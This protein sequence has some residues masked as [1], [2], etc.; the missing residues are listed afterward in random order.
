MV[1]TEISRDI[2]AAHVVNR[3]SHRQHSVEESVNTALTGRSIDD[4][5][6]SKSSND[7]TYE[8][9]CEVVCTG[10]HG[11]APQRNEGAE[12]GC[13]S[14]PRILAGSLEILT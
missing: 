12:L 1:S 6:D 10:L 2:R 7:T 13:Q 9:T 5:P 8:H 4:L 14:D 3:D 11:A